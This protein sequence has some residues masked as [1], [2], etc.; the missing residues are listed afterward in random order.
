MS[1]VR[2]EERESHALADARVHTVWVS[3]YAINH[4]IMP[5]AMETISQAG[6]RRQQAGHLEKD[7]NERSAAVARTEQ[8][9]DIRPLNMACSEKIYCA[10]E[11]GT[12][13]EREETDAA[14]RLT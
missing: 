5:A 9:N 8:T 6:G 14:T 3:A 12:E 1:F 11:P 13:R 7:D 10:R 4:A 2:Q